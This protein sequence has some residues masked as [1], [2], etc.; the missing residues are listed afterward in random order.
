M[1]DDEP[2]VAAAIRRVLASQHEVVVRGSAEEALATIG[3]G[4]RFDAILCDL[5][6]PGMTGMDLHDALARL[7][8]E[9]A[10]RI[11]VLTGGAF[12]DR[13]REFL[14]RVPL[15][16]CEKPFESRSLREMVR[17]VVG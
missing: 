7:A 2:A 12:T 16:C 17:K 15:P 3:R 11:V 4:E 13:A 8:P 5:M 14:D 1:V 9:Q 10:G 6:M